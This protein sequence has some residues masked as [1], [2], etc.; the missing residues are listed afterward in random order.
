MPFEIICL[1]NIHFWN[2]LITVAS[3][4]TF[5]VAVIAMVFP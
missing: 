3:A 2:K 1:K 5:V 4:F